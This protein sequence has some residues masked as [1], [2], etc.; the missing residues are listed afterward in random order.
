MW[1]ALLSF[2]SWVTSSVPHSTPRTDTQV[3]CSILMQ[4]SAVGLLSK[5]PSSNNHQNLCFSHCWCQITSYSC[6]LV[7]AA[8]TWPKSSSFYESLNSSTGQFLILFYLLSTQVSS[9]LVLSIYFSVVLHVWGF[10]SPP[11]LCSRKWA[12]LKRSRM[13]EF[14]ST[15]SRCCGDAFRCSA[16]TKLRSFWS[17]RN[18]F[19]RVKR[20][21]IHEK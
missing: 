21:D 19:Y 2:T 13:L 14:F 3:F 12:E 1:W 6:K 20:R 11:W 10:F 16:S 9:H 5:S 15:A 17:R 18:G 4:E 7:P 8:V